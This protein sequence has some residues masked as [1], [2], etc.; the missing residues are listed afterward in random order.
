MISSCKFMRCVVWIMHLMIVTY[1]LYK[2]KKRKRE[3]WERSVEKR[4]RII[5]LFLERLCRSL[6]AKWK[7]FFILLE[8]VLIR[9]LKGTVHCSISSDMYLIVPSI[10]ISGNTRKKMT[11]K[12]HKNPV[13]NIQ[14]RLF[15]LLKMKSVQRVISLFNVFNTFVVN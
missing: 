12:F 8:Q 9:L 3:I 10:F 1:A 4:K 2:R 11:W 6:K 13:K 5:I 14:F 7:Y 15:F